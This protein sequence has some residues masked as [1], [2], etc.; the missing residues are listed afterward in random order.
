MFGQEMPYMALLL[1]ILVILLILDSDPSD[2]GLN[3]NLSTPVQDG[4]TLK[5]HQ[6]GADSPTNPSM[7]QPPFQHHFMIQA[8]SPLFRANCLM[9]LA[10][11]PPSESN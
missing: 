9:I 5:R 1:L 10:A 6:S 8:R 7:L 4:Q 3:A 11:V 2:L